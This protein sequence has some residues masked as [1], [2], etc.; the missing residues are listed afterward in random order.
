MSDIIDDANNQAE[1]ALQLQLQARR[2][3]GPAATGLCLSCEAPLGQGLRWCDAD[4]RDSHDR[5][6]RAAQRNG[7]RDDK[8]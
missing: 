5:V 2:A 8:A 3:A 7:R 1:M 4:C 6:T